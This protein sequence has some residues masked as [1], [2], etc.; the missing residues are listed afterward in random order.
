MRDATVQDTLDSLKVAIQQERLKLAIE[1][2]RHQ[3]ALAETA[4]FNKYMIMY[5]MRP[6]RLYY[7]LLKFDGL[8]WVAIYD[9]NGEA[10]MALVGRG[11]SPEK[12]LLDFDRQWYGTENK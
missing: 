3:K 12:A 11:D 7:P 9:P 5:A 1:Q 6:C 2:A 8:E 4:E 10:G